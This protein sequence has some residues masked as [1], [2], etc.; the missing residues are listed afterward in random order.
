MKKCS[1][2]ML[3]HAFVLL[4]LAF[5]LF[6]NYYEPE[7]EFEDNSENLVMGSMAY[8][9]EYASYSDYGLVSTSFENLDGVARVRDALEDY[10]GLYG[11]TYS[12]YGSQIGLQGYVY[13]T[14]SRIFC[15]NH[16]ALTLLTMRKV[17]TAVNAVLMSIAAMTIVYITGKKYNK[18]LA[19]SFYVTFLLSTWV[20]NFAQN[21]YWVEFA[22]FLPMILGLVMSLDYEKFDRGWI[23][24][25][26]TLSI[27]LK[28][29]CGY[30]Y[31]STIMIG[32]IMFPAV[33]FVVGSGADRKRIFKIIVKMGLCALGGF[34]VTLIIHS[35]MRGGGNLMEGL[36]AIYRQDVLRRTIIGDPNAVFTSDAAVQEVLSRSIEASVWYVLRLYFKFH[37]PVLLGIRA[38]LFVPLVICAAVIFL[39]RAS[40]KENRWEL[41]LFCIAFIASISWFVLGKSHSCLHEHMNFV[42]WY[43]GFVQMCLYSVICGIVYL[44]KR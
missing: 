23:Y 29:A 43:F 27:A 34:A 42:L 7:S 36:K 24:M 11:V 19:L 14:I 2:G 10:Y 39:L 40:K 32:L 37:T 17:L 18:L 28:S 5:F 25:L 9:R 33:D 6:A 21:L 20:A 26:V 3:R 44:F 8:G 41:V 30:E 13:Q 4:V 16:D 35:F 31:L 1:L 22:W 15:T 38:E 12:C